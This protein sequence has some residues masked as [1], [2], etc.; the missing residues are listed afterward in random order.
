MSASALCA[1]ERWSR[2]DDHARNSGHRVAE[3]GLKDDRAW[4]FQKARDA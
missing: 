4:S 1:P 2:R 3:N